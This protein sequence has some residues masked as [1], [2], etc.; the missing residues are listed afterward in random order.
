MDSSNIFQR[1]LRNKKWSQVYSEKVDNHHI[2][3]E[4]EIE[5]RKAS[6]RRKWATYFVGRK[7]LLFYRQIKKKNEYR[8]RNHEH[9]SNKLVI[10]PWEAH[11]GSQF[12]CY[13]C[14]EPGLSDCLSCSTCNSVAHSM[15]LPAIPAKSFSCSMCQELYLQEQKRF[16]EHQLRIK[17]N[18]DR[19][20]YGKII[21]RFIDVFVE[22]QKFLK[23]RR[24]AI[25]LQALTRMLIMKRRFRAYWRNRMRAVIVSVKDLPQMPTG[26]TTVITVVDPSKQK[27]IFRFNSLIK[28]KPSDDAFLIPGLNTNHI[29]VISLVIREDRGGL[30]PIIKGQ[31]QLPMTDI[32]D[33]LDTPNL[34]T[35]K[36]N[37]NAEWQPDGTKRERHV[38]P[39][40]A[41]KTPDTC[42][43]VYTPMHSILSICM[44]CTGPPLDI[45]RK[46]GDA[47]NICAA[48]TKKRGM[49]K[50]ETRRT[51][52]WVV[53]A[54]GKIHFYQNYG[55]SNPRFSACLNDAEATFALDGDTPTAI[56]TYSDNRRWVFGCENAVDANKFVFA[57]NESKVAV[58][59]SSIFSRQVSTSESMSLGSRLHGGA[60]NRHGSVSMTFMSNQSTGKGF[61]GHS[62][63][64]LSLS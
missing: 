27:E 2:L 1:R 13:I 21:A 28:T 17:E 56:L 52:W 38:P 61:H 50:L 5:E 18:A 31:A 25:A 41:S 37:S 26:A 32:R 4:K 20:H 45:I 53:V 15:C 54:D 58:T 33:A 44:N 55:E 7:V 16:G 51:D 62:S 36:V 35:L 39:S 57:V 3:K 48:N 34:Y 60:H 30:T 24:A 47:H 9:D 29:I 12:L 64:T 63:K 43:L 49:K 8:T 14:N 19:H 23:K 42:V 59:G 22:R 10:V 6:A 40:T 11:L 46:H